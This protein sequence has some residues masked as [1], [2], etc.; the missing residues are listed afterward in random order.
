MLKK[1]RRASFL[2]IAAVFCKLHSISPATIQHQKDMGFVVILST[3]IARYDHFEAI[4][5]Q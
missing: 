2:R 5:R 4:Y 3:R 1:R